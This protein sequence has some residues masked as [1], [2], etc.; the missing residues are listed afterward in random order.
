MI[1]ELIFVGYCEDAKAYRLVDPKN[2]RK[3]VK[4]RNVE[5]IEVSTHNKKKEIADIFYVGGER[6]GEDN[7][8]KST[9]LS[10]K[11]MQMSMRIMQTIIVKQK[12]RTVRERPKIKYKNIIIQS[13]KEKGRNFQ[14]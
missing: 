5:F 14:I 11:R 4:A 2:P 7:N 12:M 1:K 9:V 13:V 3:I 8:Y 10:L 6:I